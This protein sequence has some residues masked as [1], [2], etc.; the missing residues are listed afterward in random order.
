MAN[1]TQTNSSVGSS[2]YNFFLSKVPQGSDYIIFRSDDYYICIYGDYQGNN[3]FKN[4][5]VIR[6]S[7][8]YNQGGQVYYSNE[9][10]TTYSI[11]YE[12]YSYSNVGTG[13]FLQDP[14]Y[15]MDTSHQLTMQTSI[16]FILLLSF[17][18]FNILRKRWI[19]RD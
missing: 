9:S 2:Y 17:I 3:T 7:T 16:L 13:T 14:R 5:T 18:G 15:N 4:S 6:I 10:T 11:S 8:A 12:Y 19:D 1:Y